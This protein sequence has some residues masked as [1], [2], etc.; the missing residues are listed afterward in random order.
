[1][2]PRDCTE[3]D[4]EKLANKYGRVKD[5]RLL[6]GFGFVEFEDRHDA[7]DCI[8]QLDGTKFMGDRIQVEAAR[9]E[10]EK[11]RP[12]DSNGDRYSPQRRTRGEFRCD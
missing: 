4:L 10:R 6:A 8:D 12:R 5:I 11:R 9:G 3:K 2:L 1:H 7:R